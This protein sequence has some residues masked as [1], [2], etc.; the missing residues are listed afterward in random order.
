M[1]CIDECVISLCYVREHGYG[2][3][4]NNHFVC[5]PSAILFVIVEMWKEAL[6]VMY[7]VGQLYYKLNWQVMAQPCGRTRVQSNKEYENKYDLVDMRF[8]ILKMGPRLAQGWVD[9]KLNLQLGVMCLRLSLENVFI[10]WSIIGNL[11]NSM[12]LPEIY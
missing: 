6:I 8:W 11:I 12:C 1:S 3:G 5:E 9:C 4:K 10:F 7:S 2:R